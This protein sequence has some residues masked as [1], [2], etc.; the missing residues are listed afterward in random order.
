[1]S[2]L[3]EHIVVVLGS[4][5]VG[6][7]AL[8]IQLVQRYFIEDY[9]PT[10]E[11]TYKKHMKVDDVTVMLDILDTAGQQAFISMRDQYLDKGD[12]FL[13][14]YS[15]T[16]RSSFEEVVSLR[17]HVLRV[18]DASS[19][20]I[21]IVGNKC[22]LT[23]QRQVE[24]DEGKKLAESFGVPHFETSARDRTNVVESFTELVREIWKL[25][26]SSDKQSNQGWCP[27]L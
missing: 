26:G 15:I 11:D 12:G 16:S 22:D 4:C 27:L 25:S 23:N 3:R 2:T 21:V 1:M 6:K 8:T 24:T 10:I 7:S 17:D 13:L 14:V 20:P 5:G 18:K 19:A 9:D